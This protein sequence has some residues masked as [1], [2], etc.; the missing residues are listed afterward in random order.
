MDG[1]IKNEWKREW[2]KER[3]EWNRKLWI[4]LREGWI[5]NEVKKCIIEIENGESEENTKS[6]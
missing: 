4:K 2:M 5:K 6:I 1:W 3:K